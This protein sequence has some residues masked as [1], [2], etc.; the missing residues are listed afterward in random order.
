MIGKMVRVMLGAAIA[1]TM[2]GTAALPATAAAG[3]I[4]RQGSCSGSTDWKLKVKPDNGRIEVEYEVD[5]NVVGQTWRVRI[6]KNGTSVFAG[7]RVTQAPSGSFE[8]RL[9]TANGVGV[10]RFRAAATNPATGE[11]CLGFASI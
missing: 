9:R 3:D 6:A 8:V 11:T 4:I 1:A 5:S 10:D 2:I 7:S